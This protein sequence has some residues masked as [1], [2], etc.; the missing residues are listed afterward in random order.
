MGGLRRVPL[1]TTCLCNIWMGAGSMATSFVTVPLQVERLL[2]PTKQFMML[3]E[4]ILIA[5]IGMF[6]NL[7]ISP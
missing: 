4:A 1:N 5:E 3:E 2:R 6:E 7:V